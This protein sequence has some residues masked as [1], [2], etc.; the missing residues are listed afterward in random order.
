MRFQPLKNNLNRVQVQ[1]RSCCY[2]RLA[3]TVTIALGCTLSAQAQDLSKDGRWKVFATLSTDDV[4]HGFSR[5]LGD[6][7]AQASIVYYDSSGWFAGFQTKTIDFVANGLP[8]RDLNVSLRGSLGYA[9]QLDDD[10]KVIVSGHYL[11]Y[12]GSTASSSNYKELFGEVFY[13][14]LLSFKIDYGHNRYTLKEDSIVYELAGHYPLALSYTLDA[15]VGYHDADDLLGDSYNYYSMGVNKRFGPFDIGLRYHETSRRGDELFNT[16]G[17][18][19]GLDLS[20]VTDS[21]FVL[22]FSARSDVFAQ[23]EWERWEG[24]RGFSSSVDIV[25]NYVSKGVSQTEDNP[26]VQLSVDY[27]WDNGIYTG[28]WVSN[29][30]YVPTGKPNDGA[31]FEVD[32]YLGFSFES[33][34]GVGLDLSYVYYDYPGIEASIESDF[35]YSEVILAASYDRWGAQIG[36]SNDQVASGETGTWYK[37][38]AD[39]DLIEKLSLNVAVGH[40]DRSNFGN[41]YNWWRVSLSYDV[42]EFYVGLTATQTSSVADRDNTGGQADDKLIANVSYSF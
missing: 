4:E 29:V 13:A 10:W 33:S 9:W 5:T 14:D 8:N 25:S 11:N 2:L 21:G 41:S 6:P 22:S 37:G 28:I 15:I 27:A 34:K 19:N 24:F 30:D 36:Y 20:D 12:P 3:L 18:A 1:G 35:D 39:F 7:G 38:T 23:S 40:Y 16:L 17:L 31:D 42:G 26:A 32:Y